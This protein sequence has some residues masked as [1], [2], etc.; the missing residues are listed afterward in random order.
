MPIIK[1]STGASYTEELAKRLDRYGI[2]RA[3]LARELGKARSQISRW[4]NKPGH[5]PSMDN[6]IQIE[7]AVSKLRLKHSKHRPA[8][9]NGK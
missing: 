2:T 8:A 6:I 1:V 4:L 5:E 7:E 3:E 9:K